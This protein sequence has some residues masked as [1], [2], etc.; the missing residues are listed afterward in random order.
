MLN[1]I[2]KNVLQPTA[3]LSIFFTDPRSAVPDHEHMFARVEI[4][5]CYILYV[6]ADVYLFDRFMKTDI[7]PVIFTTGQFVSAI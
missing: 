6:T 2:F 4:F 1:L 5:S 3:K 7:N